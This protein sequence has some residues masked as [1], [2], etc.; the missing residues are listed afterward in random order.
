MGQ[1]TKARAFVF[2][3]C[4]AGTTSFAR[5]GNIISSEAR[6]SLP[7][8]AAQMNDIEALPQ[9]KLQQVANDVMLRINEVALR[10]NGNVTACAVCCMW[11]IFSLKYAIMLFRKAVVS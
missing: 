3:I 6:T 8:C 9:M 4:A 2:F 7:P 10:A 5:K 11:L 1:N